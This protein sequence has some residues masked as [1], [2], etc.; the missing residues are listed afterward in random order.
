MTIF[1][2]LIPLVLLVALLLVACDQQTASKPLE[3][4]EANKATAS[5][6]VEGMT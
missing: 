1:K 5:F 3:I 6:A 2:S 4:S